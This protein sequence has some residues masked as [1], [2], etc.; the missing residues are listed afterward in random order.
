MIERMRR[1]ADC[2]RS[3]QG[4]DCNEYFGDLEE[5]ENLGLNFGVLDLE[6]AHG[7]VKLHTN[8]KRVQDRT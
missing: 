3:P 7:K 4:E 8:T 2:F 1:S 6:N 5:R